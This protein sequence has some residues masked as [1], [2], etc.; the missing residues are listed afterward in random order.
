MTIKIASYSLTF[1]PGKI[2]PCISLYPHWPRHI[3]MCRKESHFWEKGNKI[4]CTGSSSSVTTKLSC[5]CNYCHSHFCL[6][7]EGLLVPSR[8]M[9]AY[10]SYLPCSFCH[11]TTG[12][13]S[14]GKERTRSAQNGRTMRLSGYPKA[15]RAK[16]R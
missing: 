15:T 16:T 14:P 11:Y 13:G 10:T 7:A 5:L 1:L 9:A 2:I 8:E 12:E 4:P 3:I 6:E